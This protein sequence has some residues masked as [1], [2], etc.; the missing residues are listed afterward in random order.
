MATIDDSSEPDPKI[1]EIVAITRELFGCDPTI[2]VVHALDDP[3][4]TLTVFMHEFHGEHSEFLKKRLIW[5]NYIRD[6][7]PTGIGILSWSNV[8]TLC[9]PANS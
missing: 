3:K 8:P 2:K 4:C 9:N 1:A 5:Y 7:L 6:I